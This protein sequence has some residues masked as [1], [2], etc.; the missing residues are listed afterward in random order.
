MLRSLPGL[1]GAGVGLQR[2]AM[3]IVPSSVE[4]RFRLVHVESWD[5]ETINY[6]HGK[7]W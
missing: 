1:E 3:A 7:C 4:W 5:N 6:G 2:L